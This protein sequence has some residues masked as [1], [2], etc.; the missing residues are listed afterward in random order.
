MVRDIQQPRDDRTEAINHARSIL[1]D[2][3]NIADVMQ[4]MR[5]GDYSQIDCIVVVRAVKKVSLGEAKAIV[6][7]SPA[8]SDRLEANVEFRKS[9]IAVAEEIQRLEELGNPPKTGGFWSSIK[10]KFGF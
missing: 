6:D 2:G 5:S 1:D 7:E 8:W 9:V 10:S 3:G 4:W